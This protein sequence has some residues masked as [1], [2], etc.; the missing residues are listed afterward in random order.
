MK[1]VIE[2]EQRDRFARGLLEHV[3]VELEHDIEQLVVARLKPMLDQPGTSDSYHATAS[4]SIKL[5]R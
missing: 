5:T 1:V 4:V 2:V 3:L